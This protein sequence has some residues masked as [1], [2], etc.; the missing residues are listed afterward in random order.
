MSS[1]SVSIE[2]LSF[3]HVR[4]IDG[5]DMAHSS[6]RKVRI[7]LCNRRV[8]IAPVLRS[9]RRTVPANKGVIAVGGSG[10][11]RHLR[12]RLARQRPRSDQVLPR[13]RR[14]DS[15]WWHRIDWARTG[16]IGAIVIGA[17]SL[18]FTGVA[19]YYQ[20]RVS[21]D[22]LDQS[23]EDAAV[24]ARNQA[25]RVSFW[26]DDISTHE[27]QVHLMN[28]SPDPASHVVLLIESRIPTGRRSASGL[29]E[30]KYRHYEIAIDS[31]GPC[32]ELGIAESSLP[33]PKGDS[34]S[35]LPENAELSVRLL[36]FS[37]ADGVMWARSPGRLVT[38]E[39]PEGDAL[40]NSAIKTQP[41]SPVHLLKSYT[42]SRVESCGDSA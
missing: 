11:Q 5:A 26:I 8:S 32:M 10:D 37:A 15:R 14:S 33:Y 9:G 13:E 41:L 23:Q 39:S 31:L 2:T 22:Q 34:M 35:P 18:F 28:R 36:L 24:K 4:W 42:V 12:L 38:L 30:L 29:R 16:T 17:L 19:T 25:T 27:D 20:A 40:L 21:R 6:I 7:G 3:T 1:E